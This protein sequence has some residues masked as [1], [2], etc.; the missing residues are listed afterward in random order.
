MSTCPCNSIRGIVRPRGHFLRRICV[1]CSFSVILNLDLNYVRIIRIIQCVQ[2]PIDY[3][4]KHVQSFWQLWGKQQLSKEPKPYLYAKWFNIS[5]GFTFGWTGIGINDNFAYISGNKIRFKFWPNLAFVFLKPSSHL[6]TNLKLQSCVVT[7]KTS[8]EDRGVVNKPHP[9][10]IPWASYVVSSHR[11]LSTQRPHRRPTPTKLLFIHLKAPET[12]KGNKPTID[13]QLCIKVKAG[14]WGSA[15]S[16]VNQG[17]RRPHP[18]IKRTLAFWCFVGWR[19]LW[20]LALLAFFL[21]VFSHPSCQDESCAT[22]LLLVKCH[23]LE[24]SIRVYQGM[25]DD[26]T[27]AVICCF[28]GL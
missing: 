17:W 8:Q 6:V 19:N 18:H 1:M 16:K 13:V 10:T 15:A 11:S 2:T 21:S 9:T 20:P 12:E 5:F 3:C 14:Y 26:R 28:M 25:E 22:L 27:K 23:G 7:W 24:S 4:Q